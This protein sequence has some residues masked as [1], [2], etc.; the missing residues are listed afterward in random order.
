MRLAPFTPI[1]WATWG[2]E[3][4][5]QG[6]VV[7]TAVRLPRPR[8]HVVLFVGAIVAEVYMR[9]AEALYLEAVAVPGVPAVGLARVLYHG[10]QSLVTAWPAGVAA[11][12]LWTFGGHKRRKAPGGTIAPSVARRSDCEG[13]SQLSTP[14]TSQQTRRLTSAMPAPSILLTLPLPVKAIFAAWVAFTAAMIAAYPLPKGWTQPALHA[15]EGACILVAAVAIVRGWA[16]RHERAAQVGGYL[17][18]VEFIAA[19]VGPWAHNVFTAW[20]SVGNGMYCVAFI[21]LAWQQWRWRR[22]R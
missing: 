16:R 10:V 5:A 13:P 15:W 17:A 14:V 6:A 11:L 12:C 2:A 19:T 18:C 3:M 1:D 21:L 9:A 7:V 8:P 22:E 20:R 4:V